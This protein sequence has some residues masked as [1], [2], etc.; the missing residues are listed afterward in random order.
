M[1]KVLEGVRVLEHG[2]FIT[3]PAA[4]MLLADMGADVV[5][6][7]PQ[8]PATRSGRS[9]EACI[10]RTTRPSTATSAASRSTPRR[11]PTGKSLMRLVRDA[12]VYP[13]LPPRLRRADRCRAER[14]R[15]LNLQLIYCAISGF[16]PDGPAVNRPAYD[17]VAQAASGFLRLLVNP[18]NPRVTGPAIADL[19]TGL[20]CGARHSG[21]LYERQRTGVARRVDLSMFEAMTHFNT[22]AFQHLFSENEVMGPYSRPAFR[23]RMCWSARLASGLRCI[24]LRQ[25]RILAG[26]GRRHGTARHLPDPR[27]ATRQA[28]IA[29]QE[30]MIALLHDFCG[31]GPCGMVPAAGQRR[32]TFSDVHHRRSHPRCPGTP[33][34]AVCAG[35]APGRGHLPDGALT[36]VVRWTTGIEVTAP[37]PRVNTMPSWRM[38]G[39]PPAHRRAGR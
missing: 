22:D 27:F 30:D 34:A 4:S 6:V 13:E 20:L 16:G 21:F 14:L 29:H 7:E 35:R 39:R 19:V 32:P 18:E 36:A 3:G 8:A 28:R 25:K 2:T 31:P 37:R 17:T 24:C 12:D 1:I 38:A 23:S 11:R 10:H 5:K 33:P 9:T 15:G 26:A